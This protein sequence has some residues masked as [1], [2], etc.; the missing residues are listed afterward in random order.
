MIIDISIFMPV[1]I[2]HL[3]LLKHSPRLAAITV[4]MLPL[5][6][7]AYTVGL[8]WKFGQTVGKMATQIKVIRLDGSS[9]GLREALLRDSVAIGIALIRLPFLLFV[10]LGWEWS[11]WS[12]MSPELRGQL[13]R[14]RNPVEPWCDYAQHTW[15]WSELIVLLLNEKRRALHDFIA[16]TVVWNL[17]HAQRA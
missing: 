15:F 9:I 2:L 10:F 12:T 14:E 1:T 17:R 4:V 7:H 6:W 5:V 11:S 3:S 16:G 8:H 13:L